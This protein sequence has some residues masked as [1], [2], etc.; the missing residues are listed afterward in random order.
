[1]NVVPTRCERELS[2]SLNKYWSPIPP[3]ELMTDSAHTLRSLLF[4]YSRFTV[5]I[6]G[7]PLLI[8]INDPASINDFIFDMHIEN[9]NFS[10][11]SRWWLL[12]VNIS[13]FYSFRF[14][15]ADSSIRSFTMLDHCHQTQI[16]AHQNDTPNQL[17]IL[18]RVFFFFVKLSKS[19]RE[20]NTR[21]DIFI[22]T[23]NI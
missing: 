17:I 15:I 22:K 13:T 7:F 23:S 20:G 12:N 11:L 8:S 3:L 21:N 16:Q 10:P 19:K 6:F 4:W 14:I 1:M 9:L 18:S 2:F 5:E